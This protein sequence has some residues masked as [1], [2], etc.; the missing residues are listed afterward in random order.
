MATIERKKCNRC[1]VNM[2]FDKFKK[3]RDDSYMKLCIECNEKKVKNNKCEHN[4]QK[5]QCKHCGGSQICEHNKQKSKCKDC[6][7]S[8]F[9]KHNKQK[10]TCKDCGGSSIC[11]HNRI[12]TQCKHC[13]GSSICEHNKLKQNCKDCGGS[14]ICEHNR[15]R[16]QCKDCGGGSIC[17]HNKIKTVCKDCGGGSIC[18]HNRIRSVCKDCGGS[19]IC[20]HNRIKTQCKDCGGSSIC[21]HNKIKSTCKDCDFPSYLS[22]IVR[23]RIKSSLK[24]D[25]ELSSKEY[26]GCD[27]ETFKNHIEKTFEEGMN[28]ENY[29]EW[30]IDHIIPIKYKE[31]GKVADLEEVIKRLHYTNTQSLWASDNI[32]KGNRFIGK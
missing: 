20:E 3:K 15:I 31:D 11:E 6:R 32:A 14:Q 24:S 2:T 1:K 12:K 13:G 8:S 9:C 19:S 18:E 28:W 22:N 25:K 23:N 29:G 16:S 4:R 21:E 17:E 7:G 26:L 10:S 30:H 27:I 5:P